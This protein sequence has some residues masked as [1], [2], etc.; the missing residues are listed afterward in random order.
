MSM[1]DLQVDVNNTILS[2]AAGD[3]NTITGNSK[4]EI[5]IGILLHNDTRQ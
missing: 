5:K 2:A 4:V 3:N 1:D